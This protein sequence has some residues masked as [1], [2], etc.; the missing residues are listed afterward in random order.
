MTRVGSED[1]Y[2][3]YCGGYPT[4]TQVLLWKVGTSAPVPV[5][6]G[7]DVEDVNIGSDPDGRLWVMWEDASDRSLHAVR[8]NEDARKLTQRAQRRA[9]FLVWSSVGAL[10]LAFVAIGLY[11]I[12]RGMSQ[13]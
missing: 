12:A 8:S 4:C 5:A 9:W 13:S 7:R 6:T 10:L 3:A 11:V 2:L 1:V